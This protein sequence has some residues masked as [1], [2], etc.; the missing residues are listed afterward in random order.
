M[1]L[2][3]KTHL[4][5][6]SAT[7]RSYSGIL[8]V[9]GTLW[10]VETF[11]SSSN[12]LSLWKSCW[13]SFNNSF[14]VCSFSSLRRTTNLT[15]FKLQHTKWKYLPQSHSK[16]VRYCQSRRTHRLTT[17]TLS[18]IYTIAF[19]T[20]YLYHWLISHAIIQT[21]IN[22]IVFRDQ[23]GKVNIEIR[24]FAA[25]NRYRITSN[26]RNFLLEW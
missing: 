23:S 11:G 19:C 7:I 8:E 4:C 1:I 15:F 17:I 12:S 2:Q 13:W 18:T 22:F 24:I 16:R 10:V 9:N 14:I 25:G 21:V 3:T 6:F 26:V 20:T 5:A